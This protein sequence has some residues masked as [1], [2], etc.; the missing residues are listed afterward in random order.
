MATGAISNPALG[1]PSTGAS[2]KQSMKIATYLINLDGSDERLSA[3]SAALQKH[4]I[5]FERISAVDGR[6]FNVDTHPLYDKVR[7]LRYMGRDLVGGELG[8]YMSHIKCAE[9][10]LVSDADIAIVIEDDMACNHNFAPTII[11]A[12]QWLQ[13]HGHAD[14]QIL[15]FGN[16][17]MKLATA[18][19]PIA[20]DSK[21]AVLQHA[22]YFP[23]T[24]TGIVWSRSGAQAFLQAT[25]Q[26][27]IFCP[28]DNFFR[29]WQTRANKGY[30]FW[31]PLVETSGVGSDI[32]HST[33]RKKNQRTPY[34]FFSKQARLW[35]D[36]ALAVLAKCRLR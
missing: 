26:N 30:C 15:N 14:W 36:K 35:Q 11:Q 28:V 13:S 33:V 17:K 2:K 10:F 16:Q 24:T 27:R 12:V 21:G 25:K 20:S 22:H 9:T 34:Y 8:C 6:R 19:Q 31:P 7:T 29:Y 23:M 18:L 5:A 32:D 4:G 1:S 3:I